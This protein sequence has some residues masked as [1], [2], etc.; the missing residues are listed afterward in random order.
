MDDEKEIK[1]SKHPP[2]GLE[3]TFPIFNLHYKYVREKEN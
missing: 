1:Y 2:K 3:P